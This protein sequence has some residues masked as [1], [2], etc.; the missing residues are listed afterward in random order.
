M[1]N[2][3]YSS[4]SSISDSK[5]RNFALAIGVLLVPIASASLLLL[6]GT[7]KVSNFPWRSWVSLT[8]SSH[9]QRSPKMVCFYLWLDMVLTLL[10]A[11]TMV[12]LVVLVI[13]Y[14]PAAYGTGLLIFIIVFGK[15]FT[16][17]ISCACKIIYFYFYFLSSAQSILFHL[18]QFAL[19]RT[20]ESP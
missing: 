16:V 10:A 1:V 4:D 6:F 8:H 13:V 7:M 12:C 18:R 19:H 20:A 14:G 3:K 17:G 2:T 11:T 9:F 5:T 15:S